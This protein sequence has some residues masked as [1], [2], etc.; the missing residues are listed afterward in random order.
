[1]HEYGGHGEQRTPHGGQVYQARAVACRRDGRKPDL[2]LKRAKVEVRVKDDR[3]TNQCRE[4][5]CR[6][7][8][9]RYKSISV[10]PIGRHQHS[11][12]QYRH[13]DDDIPGVDESSSAD[14]QYD[15]KHRGTLFRQPLPTPCNLGPQYV[16]RHCQREQDE[17][18]RHHMGMQV[19]EQ[20][21]EER[22]LLNREIQVLSV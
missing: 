21:T 19:S 13:N 18:N 17:R 12:C 10:F 3:D 5:Q 1:M 9:R 20:E 15:S 2:T 6:H 8:Y 14:N 7:L 4:R 22:E 16:R 11:R